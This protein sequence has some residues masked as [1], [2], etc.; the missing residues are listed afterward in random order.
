MQ[1]LDAGLIKKDIDMKIPHFHTLILSYQ[2]W[3]KENLPFCIFEKKGGFG[4]NDGI[5]K[6]IILK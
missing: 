6:K 5:G 3:L 4:Y 2:I 1:E